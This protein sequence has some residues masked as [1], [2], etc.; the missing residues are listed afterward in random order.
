V[1]I[2]TFSAPLLLL[3]ERKACLWRSEA[4]LCLQSISERMNKKQKPEKGT[5]KEGVRVRVLLLAAT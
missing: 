3:Y 1:S 5:G 2:S 4:L